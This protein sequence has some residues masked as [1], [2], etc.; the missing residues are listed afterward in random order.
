MWCASRGT[1]DPLPGIKVT[2]RRSADDKS[3]LVGSKPTTKAAFVLPS[4]CP[5]RVLIGSSRRGFR[6]TTGQETL[7]N[8]RLE[9]VYFAP[10]KGNP[11]EVV[12]K[13]HRCVAKWCRRRYR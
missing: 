8:G 2:L 3:P 10:P 12:V 13:P 7:P 1:R 9:V 4:C 6:K 11:F 5:V